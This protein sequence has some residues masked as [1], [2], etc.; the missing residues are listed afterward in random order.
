MQNI[1]FSK[2]YYT[3]VDA[4][5]HTT[6]PLKDQILPGKWN[7]SSQD[8]IVF[9][10]LL[11]YILC[12]IIWAH[13]YVITTGGGEV[14]SSSSLRLFGSS[15]LKWK[16]LCPLAQFK[17]AVSLCWQHTRN[18][19]QCIPVQNSTLHMTDL[20]S[21]Q[22]MHCINVGCVEFYFSPNSFSQKE[23]FLFLELFLCGFLNVFLN[24]TAALNS[25]SWFIRWSQFSQ[26]RLW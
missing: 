23:F 10:L 1:Y 15:I 20:V 24:T 7:W 8:H 11:W 18:H 16:H 25:Q 22:N 12:C 13:F 21:A 17:P 5:R 4:K 19:S 9:I 2:V 6:C 14:L 26:P 3:V